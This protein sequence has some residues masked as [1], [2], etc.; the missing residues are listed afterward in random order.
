MSSAS[1]FY[2][3]EVNRQIKI[4]AQYLVKCRNRMPMGSLNWQQDNVFRICWF[5]SA[6]FFLSLGMSSIVVNPKSEKE[7]KF[8]AELL[9]KLGV[10]AKVLSDED[11]EDLG[12]SILMKDVDRNDLATE[13]E[14]MAKLKG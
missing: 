1:N 10:E 4:P 12:L 13:E 2:D 7:L 14:I 8:L 3:N 9:E 6:L 11:T 5:L